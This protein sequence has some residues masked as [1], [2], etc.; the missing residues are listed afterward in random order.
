MIAAS[1][2]TPPRTPPHTPEVRFIANMGVCITGKNGKYLVDPLPKGSNPIFPA[3]PLGAAQAIRDG[4][5][6]YDNVSMLLVTH[7]HNDHYAPEKLA[8]FAQANPQAKVFAGEEVVREARRH[9]NGARN[10]AAL[11]PPLYDAARFRHGRAEALAVSLRHSGTRF[12][13]VRNLAFIMEAD[14]PP[15]VHVGDADCAEDNLEALVAHSGQGAL[16]IVPFHWYSVAEARK[17]VRRLA[18]P[19]GM[20]L[21]HLPRPDADRWDWVPA[22]HKS[23]E[24]AKE[25]GVVI[26]GGV[27]SIVR[28]DV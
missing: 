27:G 19:R 7:A 16:L 17:L 20:L 5:P 11:S 22:L 12:A 2:H 26:A 21:C 25:P 3:P 6:P 15:L 14:G 28:W 10:F 4:E 9:A 13:D 23:V 24:A 1:Q 8:A 18:K